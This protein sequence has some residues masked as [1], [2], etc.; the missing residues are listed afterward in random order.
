[1]YDTYVTCEHDF[2]K[3]GEMIKTWESVGKS[4]HRHTAD[5]GFGGK[6]VGKGC[7]DRFVGKSGVVGVGGESGVGSRKVVRF[8]E[9][10]EFGGL[11]VGGRKVVKDDEGKG[12]LDDD[13]AFHSN[14]DEAA[15]RLK[16][17]FDSSADHVKL[18]LCENPRF[19]GS[20]S[21]SSTAIDNIDDDDDKQQQQSIEDNQRQDDDPKRPLLTT[22]NN[23]DNNVATTDSYRRR[24]QPLTLE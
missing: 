12:I 10:L 16:L 18:P 14:I 5:V 8:D 4:G 13:M 2:P 11:G 19:D 23:D 6:G 20:G 17:R 24:S 15:E 21:S 1:M 22:N 3:V 7:R 9:T